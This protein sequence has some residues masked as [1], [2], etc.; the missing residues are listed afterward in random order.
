MDNFH[1]LQV[2][3]TGIDE[4]MVNNEFERMAHHFVEGATISS[5]CLP[6]TVL[7]VQVGL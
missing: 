1:H 3:T 2:C 4:E 5:P 6:L 7:V